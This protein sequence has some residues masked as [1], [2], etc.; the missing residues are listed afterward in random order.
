M[1]YL[2][3]CARLIHSVQSRCLR[4]IELQEMV[5]RQSD[6]LALLDNNSNTVKDLRLSEFIL[7]GSWSVVLIWIKDHCS[8]EF[9]SAR[10]LLEFK[11]ETDQAS[12]PQTLL[13]WTR[14]VFELDV[15]H[16]PLAMS[17]TPTRNFLARLGASTS[18]A[19]VFLL[20]G[21]ESKSR[22]FSVAT[23]PFIFSASA[24]KMPSSFSVPVS[25]LPSTAAAFSSSSSSLVVVSSSSSASAHS[26]AYSASAAGSGLKVSKSSASRS[27][28]LL[29][30]SEGHQ[31]VR[32]DNMRE[33]AYSNADEGR[34]A[35]SSSICQVMLELICELDISEDG[36]V[37]SL[38]SVARS[39]FHVRRVPAA[40]LD[41]GYDLAH[42]SCI[43][44]N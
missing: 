19:I 34:M 33:K 29:V 13:R 4:E 5:C 26:A 25:P 23:I 1:E 44:W 8:S 17:S 15:V 2:D 16:I 42:L 20:L 38:L 3:I 36:S 12:K 30:K 18:T 10:K 35:V 11:D 37:L 32:L 28:L 9:M 43:H 41:Q 7:L 14:S 27:R 22:H 40:T 6:I 31:E 21:A 39:V 24:V